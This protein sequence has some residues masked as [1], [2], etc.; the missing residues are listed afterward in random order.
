MN[1]CPEKKDLIAYCMDM[2]DQKK[3]KLIEEQAAICQHCRQVIQFESAIDKELSTRMDPG[4]IDDIILRKLRIYKDL[5][6]RSWWF[7][8]LYVFLNTLAGCALLFGIWI[9]VSNQLGDRSFSFPILGDNTGSY[10]GIGISIAVLLAIFGFAFRRNL[11]RVIRV[12]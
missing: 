2:L 8:P 11:A 7:Y 6:I 9:S 12:L 3:R 4:N 5:R 10:I 1:S